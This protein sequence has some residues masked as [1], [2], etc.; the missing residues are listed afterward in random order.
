MTRVIIDQAL[1]AKL[2]DLAEALVLC[3]EHGNVFGHFVPM[4]DLAQWEPESPG[5]N[6]EELDRRAQSKERRY[7]TAEVL[8]RLEELGHRGPA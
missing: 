2:H 6:E 5:I 4:V 3:D 8:A 1:R 7:S